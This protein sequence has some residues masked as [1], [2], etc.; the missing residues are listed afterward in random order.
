MLL[1]V[2][3][4]VAGPVL[5]R[6]FAWAVGL[7]LDRLGMSSRLAVANAKRNPSRTAN[8]ANALVIGMFLV[9]FV[10]AA[11]GGHPRLG[12]QGGLAVLHRRPRT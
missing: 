8:T 12:G 1:F 2:G 9:V 7:V 5:A 3:T 6:G 4:L 11:G 10:T